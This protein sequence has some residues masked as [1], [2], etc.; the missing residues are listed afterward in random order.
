MVLMSMEQEQSF[1]KETQEIYAW[2]MTHL[3]EEFL[4]DIDSE[5]DPSKDQ[6]YPED[7]DDHEI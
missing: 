2:I 1:K 5:D 3:D 4:N 6:C 7:P